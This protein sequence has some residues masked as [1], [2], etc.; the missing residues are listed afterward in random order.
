MACKIDGSRLTFH[1]ENYAR[2]VHMRPCFKAS[3][4]A[5]ATQTNVGAKAVEWNPE[6]Q[7]MKHIADQEALPIKGNDCCPPPKDGSA[8]VVAHANAK[9]PYQL[10]RNEG[11]AGW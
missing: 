5:A 2:E 6:C 11:R 7:N 9:V 4:E 10:V 1:T 3:Q 8:R